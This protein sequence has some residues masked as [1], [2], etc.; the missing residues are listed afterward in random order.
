MEKQFKKDMASIT[1]S[2]RMDGSNKVFGQMFELA[3]GTKAKRESFNEDLQDQLQEMM[4]VFEAD[5]EMPQECISCKVLQSLTQFDTFWEKTADVLND[6]TATSSRRA[7]ATLHLDP[8]AVATKG[9]SRDLNETA[10]M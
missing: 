8:N 9:G 7:S 1:Q 2:S 10:T 4:A 6:I 3:T 5:Y